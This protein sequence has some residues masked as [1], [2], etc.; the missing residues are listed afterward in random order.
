MLRKNAVPTFS[1]SSF[2]LTLFS[3]D[4]WKTWIES[5]SENASQDHQSNL[6]TDQPATLKNGGQPLRQLS[7]DSY[8]TAHMYLGKLI[9]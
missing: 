4:K 9:S 6:Y 2:C 1:P 7:L 8:C 5:L 3:Y